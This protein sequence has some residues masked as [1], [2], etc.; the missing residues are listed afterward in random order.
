MSMKQT[1]ID[2]YADIDGRIRYVLRHEGPFNKIPYGVKTIVTDMGKFNELVHYNQVYGFQVENKI[3]VVPKYTEE[4]KKINIKRGYIIPDGEDWYS[5]IPR[6]KAEDIQR[7]LYDN[8][9]SISLLYSAETN[10]YFVTQFLMFR[11]VPFQKSE[12]RDLK[13]SLHLVGIG[14]VTDNLYYAS[15]LTGLLEMYLK[16]SDYRQGINEYKYGIDVR[17]HENL[18]SVYRKNLPNG[19]NNIEDNEIIRISNIFRNMKRD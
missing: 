4:E 18:S 7:S 10:G 15:T 2:A 9:L 3:S 19:F 6:F 13:R 14:R 1:K 8:Y 12:L 16:E 17:V 11:G 5:N